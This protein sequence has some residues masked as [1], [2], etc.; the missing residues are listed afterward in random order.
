MINDFARVSQK[1]FLYAGAKDRIAS[2]T[3][4]LSQTATSPLPVLVIC[5]GFKAFKDWGFFP[6]LAKYFAD[7]GFYVVTF[8]LSHNGCD[9]AGREEADLSAFKENCFSFEEIDLRNIVSDL[10]EKKLPRASLADYTN[11]HLLG[12]SRG[13]SAIIRCADIEEVRSLIFLAS[14]CRYPQVSAEEEKTWRAEGVLWIEN[15]RTKTKLPLGTQLLEEM[16]QDRDLMEM[17]AKKLSKSICLIHGSHDLTVPATAASEL[18]S[19]ALNSELHLL[20]GAGHTFEMKHPC[21]E[22]TPAFESVLA[23]SRAFLER[24]SQ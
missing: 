11:I 19:W 20:E 12:H 21:R 17:R 9:E 4:F 10:R 14:I 3:V 6:Y 13:G 8:N 18:A 15:Q 2:G 5:H 16:I 22:I 23:L 1:D 7:Q 24:S